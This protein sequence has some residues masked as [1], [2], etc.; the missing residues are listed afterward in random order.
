MLFIML[1]RMKVRIVSLIS[2]TVQFMLK[3]F[4]MTKETFKKAKTTICNVDIIIMNIYALS[5]TATTFM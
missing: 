4:K 2:V 5:N 3:I 1:L